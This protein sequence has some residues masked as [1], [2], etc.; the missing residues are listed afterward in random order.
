MFPFFSITNSAEKYNLVRASF[1]LWA[2]ISVGYILAV[3]LLSLR[4]CAF[5][6]LIDVAQLASTK[7]VQWA[8]LM[9]P[10]EH[11]HCI[12]ITLAHLSVFYSPATPRDPLIS[13]ILILF[14]LSS[15]H[16]MKYFVLILN[17]TLK[18]KRTKGNW[19]QKTCVQVLAILLTCLWHWAN[20][21]SVLSLVFLISKVGSGHH[22]KN[23]VKMK[24]D[25]A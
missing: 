3:E 24:R 19:N 13:V 18:R 20:H 4:S 14:F 23:F 21:S 15:T 9:F 12:W 22:L 8:G 11:H 2:N 7:F 10:S 25:T 5:V 1:S 17:N 6:I 16:Y